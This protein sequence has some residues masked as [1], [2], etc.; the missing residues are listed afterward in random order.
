MYSIFLVTRVVHLYSDKLTFTNHHLINT[1]ISFQLLF[2]LFLL[3]R[4]SK[5]DDVYTVFVDA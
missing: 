4:R 5:V 3:C 1:N 2:N